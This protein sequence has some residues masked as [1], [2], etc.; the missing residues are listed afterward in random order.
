MSQLKVNSIIPTGGVPTG[1]G[2][3]VTQIKSTVK[4][5]A[6]SSTSTSYTDVTGLNV[7]IT[8]TSSSNKVLIIC[9]I[10]GNG[11]G[12]T[13]GYFALARDS[14][15]TIFLGNQTGSRVRATLN[16]YNNQNNECKNGTLVFLDSP[17][18][19]SSVT[20]KIQCRTQGQGTVNINRSELF[21][22]NAN[23][24]TLTSSITAMEVS[25]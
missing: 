14:D 11:T 8:P 13:Q 20:Y 12:A 22:N 18:T 9:Q 17:S 7:S 4:L 15:N 16:M 5:D 10:S 21:Q 3:G 23:S 2:G 24:G 25:G 1:G 19:T 6:F